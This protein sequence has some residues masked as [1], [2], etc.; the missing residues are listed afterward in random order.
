MEYIHV[1]HTSREPPGSHKAVGT[2]TSYDVRYPP[3]HSNRCCR[4][5]GYL[6]DS[7]CGLPSYECLDMNSLHSLPWT[8]M[9][10][11]CPTGRPWVLLTNITW[12]YMISRDVQWMTILACTMIILGC[13][14]NGPYTWAALC[15]L[16][17]LILYAILAAIPH[18]V[19]GPWVAGNNF[20]ADGGIALLLRRTWY[21]RTLTPKRP[22]LVALAL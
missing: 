19:V 22:V 13:E 10:C 8:F 3:T 11:R 9:A 14:T 5:A 21:R 7:S 17:S 6:A 15:A 2:V 18:A 1:L 12:Q 16:D 4:I 20:E